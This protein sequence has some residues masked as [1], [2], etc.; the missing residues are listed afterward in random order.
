MKLEQSPDWL[1]SLCKH[2]RTTQ[3]S[4]T[5]IKNKQRNQMTDYGPQKKMEERHIV[6]SERKTNLQTALGRMMLMEI[7]QTSQKKIRTTWMR[8]WKKENNRKDEC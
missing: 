4:E 5:K 3:N 6:V 8:K 7:Y 2:L 1:M